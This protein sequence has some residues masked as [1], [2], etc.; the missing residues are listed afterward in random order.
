METT[1]AETLAMVVSVAWPSSMEPAPNASV[2]ESTTPD[3]GR[4]EQFVRVPLAG[5]PGTGAVSDL[6]V[7]V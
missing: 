2:V 4:P 6:L 3:S 1:P 5:V 7:S